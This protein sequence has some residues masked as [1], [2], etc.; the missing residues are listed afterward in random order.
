MTIQ[1]IVAYENVFERILSIVEI[2]TV[3]EGGVV[4]EDC[5][6]LLHQ[7]L[8]SN[9]QN[10]ILFKDGRFV[11][12]LAKLF[13]AIPQELEASSTWSAQKLVNVSWLLKVSRPLYLSNC[14]SA[15]IHTYVIL[16]ETV[17][18]RSLLLI[19]AMVS[20]MK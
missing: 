13:E 15:H 2:E 7:L 8:A 12:R 6:R 17:I 3:S 1:K 16:M 14:N 20:T 10:Q 18:C 4:I 19:V 5:F 9:P 11:Q